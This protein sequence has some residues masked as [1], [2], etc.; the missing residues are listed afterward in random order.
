MHVCVCAYRCARVCVCVG[1]EKYNF[2]VLYICLTERRGM[3]AGL[4]IC[5]Y[6]HSGSHRLCTVLLCVQKV[7]MC[8]CVCVLGGY[9]L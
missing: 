6:V 1:K 7:T 5:L 2:Y 8:V 4:C 3:G 9:F